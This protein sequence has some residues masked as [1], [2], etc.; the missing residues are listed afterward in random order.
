MR[1]LKLTTIMPEDESYEM[2]TNGVISKRVSKRLSVLKVMDGAVCSMEN[3]EALEEWRMHGI[4]EDITCLEDYED[5]ALDHIRY[6]Y[7]VK[8]FSNIV[9]KYG[10][11][12]F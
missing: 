7:V 12:D 10:K 8:V 11:E 9:R 1:K 6:M 2:L 3:K 4:P 5:I